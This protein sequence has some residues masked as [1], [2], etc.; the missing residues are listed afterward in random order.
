MVWAGFSQVGKLEITF[1]K[2]KMNSN[3]YQELLKDKLLPFIKQ[4]Q[5]DKLTLQ[6]DNARA[7]VSKCTMMWLKKI[8]LMFFLGHLDLRT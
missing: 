7:H 6:Q 8:M 3:G 5:K 2:S 1:I 4:H